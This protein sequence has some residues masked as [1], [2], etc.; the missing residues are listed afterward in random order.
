MTDWTDALF[1]KLQNL[2]NQNSGTIDMNNVDDVIRQFLEIIRTHIT[3][4]QQHEIYYQIEM[5]S[6]QIISLKTDVSNISEEVLDEDFIP[7][8]TMELSAVV[9]QTERS[10]I[11][12]LDIADEMTRLCDEIPNL[13]LREEL[14]VKTVKILENCNFQDLTGQRIKKIIDRLS[15]IE[16]TIYK[17][18]HALRPNKQLR[19]KKVHAEKHLLNGP[20]KE[21]DCPSQEEVD[22]LFNSL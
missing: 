5:I 16:S 8:V 12:I 9:N 22:E 10:V 19:T 21:L 11:N 6:A 1:V 3:T 18:L 20:Q 4:A 17:M 7:Q 14:M 2:Q 15:E 13:K